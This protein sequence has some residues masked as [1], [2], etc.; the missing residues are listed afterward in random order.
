MF[1]VYVDFLGFGVLVVA[2]VHFGVLGVF[3]A[4]ADSGHTVIGK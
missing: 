1:T 4:V 2:F 3:N